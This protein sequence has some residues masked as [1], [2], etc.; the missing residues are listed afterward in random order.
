MKL[1]SETA[2]HTRRDPSTTLPPACDLSFM[3]LKASLEN[4]PKASVVIARVVAITCVNVF[5]VPWVMFLSETIIVDILWNQFEGFIP[6]I[7]QAIASVKPPK[8][9]DEKKFKQ[10]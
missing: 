3:L 6:F 4:F 5:A 10:V 2:I 9:V 1:T 8:P 7:I